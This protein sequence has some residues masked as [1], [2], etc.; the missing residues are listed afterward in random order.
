MNFSPF[1]F[2]LSKNLLASSAKQAREFCYF[3]L[4][5]SCTVDSVWRVVLQILL[6]HSILKL[7]D[8]HVQR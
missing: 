8:T 7:T 5:D 2:F 6:C 4:Y 1:N 3:I